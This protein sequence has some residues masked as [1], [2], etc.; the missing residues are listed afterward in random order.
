M[1]NQQDQ[2]LFEVADLVDLG[3]VEM[4]LKRPHDG[5][6]LVS[7]DEEPPFEAPASPSTEHNSPKK[8]RR[9]S[10]FENWARTRP[11]LK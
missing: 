2:H 9:T 3:T 1:R 4:A 5:E 10:Q 6:V 8:R 7:S 11:W